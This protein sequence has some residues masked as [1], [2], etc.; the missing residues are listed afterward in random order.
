[1]NNKQ[2][3]TLFNVSNNEAELF[4]ILLDSG[5]LGATE[6]AKHAG[7]SRT[8]VYD[9]AEYL[10]EVGLVF[11]SLKNGIKKFAVQPPQKITQLL[12]E[13]EKNISEAKQAVVE[14]E[15]IYN[16]KNISLK[17]RLKMF[18]G[19]AELQQMMKDLLL[20]RDITVQ[21]YW[22]VKKMLELLTPEFMNKFHAERVAR[23]IE[24]QVIWPADQVPSATAHKF[25]G[26]DVGL[27][28]QARIAPKNINFTLGYSVYSNTVRFISSSRENFGFLVESAELADMMRGQFEI[29][30]NNSKTIKK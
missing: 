1:M 23:N 16:K 18:E 30:W 12:E 22:P 25:L 14:L 17:P 8:A 21:A 6:L 5:S 13:K 26:T 19:K 2:F 10:I 11:E 9:L 15:Q 4:W 20:Y 3:L 7:I 28:R 29:L 27:K 24:L